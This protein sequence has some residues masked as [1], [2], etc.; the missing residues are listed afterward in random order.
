MKVPPIPSFPFR[1]IEMNADKTIGLL[2]TDGFGNHYIW[3]NGKTKEISD[4]EVRKDRKKA[5]ALFKKLCA[6]H[7][8]DEMKRKGEI[9]AG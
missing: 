5:L 7:E 1:V 2:T 6:D 8:I 4:Y 3:M 9:L